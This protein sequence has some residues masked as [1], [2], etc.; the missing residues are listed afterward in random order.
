MKLRCEKHAF[1]KGLQTV[2]KAVS[3]KNTIFV[4]SGILLEADGDELVFKATDMEIAIE[5]RLR[6]V[7][8]E[9]EGSLILPGRYI[10]ELA[11]KLPETELALQTDHLTLMIRYGNSQLEINGYDREEFP[12]FPQVKGE[13]EGQFSLAIFRKYIREVAVASAA[14]ETRPLFT[15][16]LFDLAADTM[17]IVA[18]DT[19]RLALKDCRWQNR[20]QK[21]KAAVVVPN[22]V[23]QEIV[24]LDDGD[25]EEAHLDVVIGEK[26]VSFQVANTL[27]I[28]RLLEGK[29]PNYQQVIPAADKVV[30]TVTL[31]RGDLLAAVERASIMVREQ[32]RERVGRI[33]LTVD[34]QFVIVDSQAPEIGR[35]HEEISAVCEGE[36]IEVHCNS[37]YL[38]DILRVLEDEEITI[39]FT[40][41]VKPMIIRVK[42]NDTYLY[43]LLPLKA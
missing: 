14:D 31:N 13:I 4:L 10:L 38:L 25:E 26:Q 30:T 11:K 16:L 27:F 7:T 3:A 37:R 21:E 15:G 17:H 1:V 20:G 12:A 22:K 29:F 39:G 8:I 40:G 2:A 18:T 23:L 5:Y 42:D 24:R 6:D 41:A 36:G 32:M 34:E 28:S 33:K 19:H 9:E 43:L 35:I